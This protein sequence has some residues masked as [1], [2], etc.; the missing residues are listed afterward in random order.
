MLEDQPLREKIVHQAL[1]DVRKHTF[2]VKF[3]KI[4]HIYQS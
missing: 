3:S 2:E 1:E 4:M